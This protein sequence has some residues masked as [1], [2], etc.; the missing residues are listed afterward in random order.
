MAHYRTIEALKGN[1]RPVI[2]AETHFDGE[3][4]QRPGN[5]QNFHSVLGPFGRLPIKVPKLIGEV[6]V[7]FKVVVLWKFVVIQNEF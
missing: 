5:V 1:E 3:G 4:P 7:L 2:A 6:S